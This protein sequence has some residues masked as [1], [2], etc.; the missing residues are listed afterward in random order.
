MPA[1]GWRKRQ[2]GTLVAEIDEFE[3]V[4][5]ERILIEEEIEMLE[6]LIIYVAKT[7]EGSYREQLG[8]DLDESLK[9]AREKLRALQ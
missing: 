9:L 2:I 7:G 6:A 4:M 8:V 5:A 3:E 1:N